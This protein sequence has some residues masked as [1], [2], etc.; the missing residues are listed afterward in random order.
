[1][2]LFNKIQTLNK[3]L[4]ITIYVLIGFAILGVVIL[5]SWFTVETSFAITSD[6]EF[7]SLCHSMKPL[8]ASNYDNSHGGDNHLGVKPKCTSC[9]L[10]HDNQFNY[11]TEKLITGIHDVAIEAFVDPNEIDWQAKR[12]H[13]SNYVYDSGC[14]SCHNDLSRIPKAQEMHQ[15]YLAG[16]LDSMCIDCHGNIGH[17]NLNKY[18]LQN[19]YK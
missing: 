8:A 5:L 15:Q 4:R 13:R 19:K 14:M 1:M 11:L 6:S 18:L 7:C 10:P 17:S 2:N 16:E 9:H 12:E 3:S